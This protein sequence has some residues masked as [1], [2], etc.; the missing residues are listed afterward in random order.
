[1]YMCLYVCTYIYIYDMHGY[2]MLF[3]LSTCTYMYM[4]LIR[5]KIT[6]PPCR[7]AIRPR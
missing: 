5:R 4:F 7:L 3:I 2:D 6:L 1:M